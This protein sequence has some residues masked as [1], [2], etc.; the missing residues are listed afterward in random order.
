MH[1][2]DLFINIYVDAIYVRGLYVFFLNYKVLYT[3]FLIFT[4]HLIL[5]Y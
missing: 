2:K 5:F 3:L 1:F 4:Y